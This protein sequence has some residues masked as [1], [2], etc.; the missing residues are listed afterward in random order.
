M[1]Q[2]RTASVE[3]EQATA[4]WDISVGDSHTSVGLASDRRMASVVSFL[5]FTTGYC[6]S[7]KLLVELRRFDYIIA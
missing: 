5:F 2:R 3:V 1:R 7:N 6:Y 4:K